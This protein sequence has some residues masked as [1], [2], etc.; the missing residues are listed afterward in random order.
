MQCLWDESFSSFNRSLMCKTLSSNSENFVN[1]LL[2]VTVVSKGIKQVVT[3]LSDEI[4]IS[5]V[6][7]AFAAPGELVYCAVA[8]DLFEQV[9]QNSPSA[10]PESVYRT[11]IRCARW[12]R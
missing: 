4:A 9:S 6:C 1:A 5:E 3:V 10:A 8:H 2:T 11:N 12:M 7:P